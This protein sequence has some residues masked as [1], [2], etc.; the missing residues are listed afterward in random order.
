[1]AGVDIGG[2]IYVDADVVIISGAG[3]NTDVGVD[4]GVSLV[5]GRPSSVRPSSINSFYIYMDCTFSK[6]NF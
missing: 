4:I 5:P 3:N 6:H 2:H 1:M